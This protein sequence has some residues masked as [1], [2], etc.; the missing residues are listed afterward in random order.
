ML[1]RKQEAVEE[2]KGINM[3]CD[4]ITTARLDL[5]KADIPTLISALISLGFSIE[6]Q[7]DNKIEA[8]VRGTNV[9]W[10][11]EGGLKIN[12]R[13]N[14]ERWADKIQTTYT[15]Q[16]IQTVSKRYGWQVKEI[17][18]GNYQVIRR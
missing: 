7:T 18:T 4:T 16:V 14:A 17:A 12:S 5:T 15:S 2:W 3:P 9:T 10:T 13:Y 11:R 8:F 6:Q 1:Q